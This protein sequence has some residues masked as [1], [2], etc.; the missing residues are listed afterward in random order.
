MHTHMILE[1][2]VQ[3]RIA[4]EYV[5]TTEVQAD[6]LTKALEG[7]STWLQLYQLVGIGL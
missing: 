2:V 4:I 7:C 3:M 6:G 5:H 1:A